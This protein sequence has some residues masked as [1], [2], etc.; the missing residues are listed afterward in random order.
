MQA[1][2]KTGPYGRG[3]TFLIND[4]DKYGY[5]DE[6]SCNGIGNEAMIWY[7]NVRGLAPSTASVCLANTGA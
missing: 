7:K 6:E 1:W 2:K 4:G 3:Y 5:A